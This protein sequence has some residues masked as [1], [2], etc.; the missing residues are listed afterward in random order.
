MEIVLEYGL[1]AL[2][3]GFIGTLI[4]RNTESLP[5]RIIAILFYIATAVMI[6]I[7]FVKLYA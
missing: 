3:L 6:V 5:P 2:I 1:I 7:M 4:I